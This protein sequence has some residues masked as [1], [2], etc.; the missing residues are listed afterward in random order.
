M[1]GGEQ[2][3][4]LRGAEF[5]L[6]GGGD[7]GQGGL[8]ERGGVGFVLPVGKQRGSIGKAQLRVFLHAFAVITFAF[9]AQLLGAIA[10]LRFGG[11]F[12]YLGRIEWHIEY[13]SIFKGVILT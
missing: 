5:G 3:F 2:L 10:D 6:H 4:A 7:F 12:F 11:A 8:V 1:Q 9:A 13:K